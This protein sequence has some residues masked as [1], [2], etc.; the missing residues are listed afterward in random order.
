MPTRTLP[1]DMQQNLRR[2]AMGAAIA[3]GLL[4]YGGRTPTFSNAFAEQVPGLLETHQK[5]EQ[6]AAYREQL[7]SMGLNEVQIMSLLGAEPNKRADIA[8][9]M[10]NVNKD[11]LNQLTGQPMYR[12]P[13]NMEL[14]VASGARGMEESA[15][16]TALQTR[17]GKIQ[18]LM[19]N[20]PGMTYNQAASVVDG[21]QRI[22]TDPVT[23]RQIVVDQVGVAMD[24]PEAARILHPSRPTGVIEP[25]EWTQGQQSLTT[26]G[27]GAEAGIATQLRNLTNRVVGSVTG[28]TVFPETD[29]MMISLGRLRNNSTITLTERVSG[30][31]SNYLLQMFEGMTWDPTEWLSNPQTALRQLTEFNAAVEQQRAREEAIVRDPYS[32]PAKRLQEAQENLRALNDL[33]M[34]YEAAIELFS[35]V[36]RVGEAGTDGQPMPVESWQAL[37]PQ[38]QTEYVGNMAPPVLPERAQQL[39]QGMT[40]ERRRQML[41]VWQQEQGGGQ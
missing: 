40:P 27:A 28:Q 15:S 6:D 23:G 20:N 13:T 17:A 4:A 8:F 12:A 22:V 18:D 39:W 29:Q 35:A 38:E 19:A 33:S 26:E 34:D 36:G 32:V 24:D 25:P 41:R 5:Q 14:E 31:P 30:R 1:T 37:S 11:V 3:D 10:H 2:R 9:G 16:T 7:Q 21:T